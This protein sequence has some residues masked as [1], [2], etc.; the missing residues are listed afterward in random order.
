[1]MLTAKPIVTILYSSAYSRFYL[2]LSIFAA[3][4]LSVGLGGQ[5]QTPL[6]AGLNNTKLNTY[7]AAISAV[8][9]LSLSYGLAMGLNVF[10]VALATTIS[11]ITTAAVIHIVI[12]R[13]LG[14]KLPKAKLV[15]VYLAG[16]LSAAPLIL[17]PQKIF[18]HGLIGLLE[19]ALILSVYII[20]YS[21]VLPLVRGV[22]KDELALISHSLKGVPILGDILAALTKYSQMFIHEHTEKPS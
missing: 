22:N 5:T 14:V 20:I 19:L 15:A 1:M 13:G 3:G 4:Y 16:A 10:G 12:V 21:T 11:T 2:L 6:F 18:R 7:S 8:S 9:L 17:I